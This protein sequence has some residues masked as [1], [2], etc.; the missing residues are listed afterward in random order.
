MS[1]TRSPLTARS[2]AVVTALVA[3]GVLAGGVSSAGAEPSEPV[4]P[5]PTPFSY[6][7][8]GY[9]SIAFGAR[10]VILKCKRSRRT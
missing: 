7:G 1:N 6:P 5:D 8:S 3:A 2:R 4:E 9:M 10:I